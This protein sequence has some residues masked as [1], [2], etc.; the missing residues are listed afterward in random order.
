M[1][2]SE[3]P[4]TGAEIDDD[5]LDAAREKLGGWSNDGSEAGEKAKLFRLVADFQRGRLVSREPSL[6]PQLEKPASDP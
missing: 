1:L 2:R 5:L 3:A 4:R 6:E